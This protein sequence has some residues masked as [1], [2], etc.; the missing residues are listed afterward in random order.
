MNALLHRLARFDAQRPGFA[1]EHWMT[2]GMGMWLLTRSRSRGLARLASMA[3]GAA[4]IG[5]SV[6]G[7]KGL[8]A[9]LRQSG[10]APR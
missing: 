2:F 10:P 8:M 9:R 3:A 4:L 5:R 7:R 1:G 6:S